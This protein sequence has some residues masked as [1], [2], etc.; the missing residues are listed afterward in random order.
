MNVFIHA[1]TAAYFGLTQIAMAFLKRGYRTDFKES[2][3]RTPLS[4]AAGRG[5]EGVVR[6][7]IDKGADKES[8]DSYSRT[9]L[10]CYASVVRLL[11]N[12][13]ANPESK[14]ASGWTPLSW[15]SENGHESVVRLLLEK[16]AD[17][18]HRG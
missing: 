7:L 14:D 5:H 13:G 1:T 4:L 16:G 12:N 15:A 3:G 6:V 2:N 17:Q 18:R 11:L 8:R 9:P 10:F